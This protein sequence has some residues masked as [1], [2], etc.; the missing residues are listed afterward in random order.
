MGKFLNY[1]VMKQINLERLKITLKWE[2][3]IPEEHLNTTKEALK[4]ASRLKYAKMIEVA[5]R[6]LHFGS[7]KMHNITYPGDGVR[8]NPNTGQE[9]GAKDDL[10]ILNEFLRDYIKI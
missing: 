9:R 3:G 2:I 5:F 1:T 4:I 6:Y 7:N 8:R 10:M